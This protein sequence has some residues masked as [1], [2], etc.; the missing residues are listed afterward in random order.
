[1]RLDVTKQFD[2]SSKQTLSP[3][4]VLAEQ[5]CGWK[6]VYMHAY[7]CERERESKGDGGRL[8]G[9]SKYTLGRLLFSRSCLCPLFL[10]TALKS[11]GGEES[12]S[13]LE[14]GSHLYMK[15]QPVHPK[16]ALLRHNLSIYWHI[17]PFSFN[18]FTLKILW[19]S[20]NVNV[21]KEKA[22]WFIQGS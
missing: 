21:P 22:L 6:R 13:N 2:I 15:T 10:S 4:G 18:P 8:T 5:S 16:P 19:T 9:N 14:S 7:V 17:L 12:E 20:W 11:D 3:T 1:M